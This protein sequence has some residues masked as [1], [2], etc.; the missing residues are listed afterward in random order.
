MAADFDEPTLTTLY[1]DWPDYITDMFAALAKMTHSSSLH[2]PVGAISWDGSAFK[3][4]R[5][6][7]DSWEDLCDEYQIIVNYAASAGVAVY[8]QGH[9][10]RGEGGTGE[11]PA[12]T[13]SL[14]G[15]MSA[16]DKTLIG[17]WSQHVKSSLGDPIFYEIAGLDIT[18]EFS[19]ASWNTVGPTDSG[20]DHIWTAMDV[21]PTN[22]DWIE[23]TGSL[24]IET[25]Y[26]SLNAPRSAY[27]VL[28]KGDSIQTVNSKNIVGRAG[29]YTNGVGH[30]KAEVQ[31]FRKIPLDSGKKFRLL[32]FAE[33]GCTPSID[34]HITGCGVN[35]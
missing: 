20:A 9:V 18:A 3:F 14:A 7:G 11:H 30:G 13:V 12:A 8:L 19:S 2:I 10:H 25:V 6:D 34:L 29:Y 4:K 33:A 16:A 17:K 23:V 27:L 35:S 21:L 1:S 28:Q 15:F 31:F 26:G 5:W 24:S 32:F 22:V